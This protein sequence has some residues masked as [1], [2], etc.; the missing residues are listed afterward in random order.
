M[1]LR[2]TPRLNAVLTL[3]EDEA[4]ALDHRW[5]GVEHVLL[6]ILREGESIVAPVVGVTHEDVVVYVRRWYGQVTPENADR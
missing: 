2:Y 1:S 6:A 5:V 3:A 4:R